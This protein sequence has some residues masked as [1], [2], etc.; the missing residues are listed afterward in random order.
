[1]K[2]GE[3]ATKPLATIG[4]GESI[5]A[6]MAIMDKRQIRHL[7]VVRPDGVCV[8]MIS[9][10]DVME[11]VG[12]LPRQH[13]LALRPGAATVSL[14]RVEQIMSIPFIGLSPEH[15]LERAIGL[16][17]EKRI[18]A[19]PIVLEQRIVGIVTSTDLLRRF[20]DN[21][22][23]PRGGWRFQRIED[24]MSSPVQ[25][26]RP[27]EPLARARRLM[28][29]RPIRHI[30]VVDDGALVGMASDRDIRWALGRGAAEFAARASRPARVSD[31][32]TR[33]VVSA[34]PRN[35]LVEA[36]ECMLTRRIGCL[37]VMQ[38]ERLLGILTQSD[39]LRALAAAYDA[40]RRAM[41]RSDEVPGSALA[42]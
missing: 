5:D 30:P 16:M 4:A 15:P 36:A 26:L 20:L 29:S 33:E 37:P 38:Q 14:T 42:V 27:E 12:W 22:N 3:I 6:A 18:N 17:L 32:M 25:T 31:I 1:M 39:L 8:G 40:P 41:A 28:R 7:P 34:E 13:R 24:W 2:L 35:T 9:D 21:L 23:E 19:V 10:R 11:A